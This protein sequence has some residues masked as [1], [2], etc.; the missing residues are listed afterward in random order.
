MPRIE[1]S[2]FLPLAMANAREVEVRISD[3]QGD[4]LRSRI[5]QPR[6]K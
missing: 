5:W 6:T 2:G 3:N 4:L 1:T